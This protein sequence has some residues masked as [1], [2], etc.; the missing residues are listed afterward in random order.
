[1]PRGARTARILVAEQ[2]DDASS[3]ANELRSGGY[4]TV[5]VRSGAQMLG[6]ARDDDAQTRGPMLDPNSNVIDVYVGYLRRKLGADIIH[7]VRG[8]GYRLGA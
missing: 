4:S 5:A 2:A 8:V 6:L 3:L 1:M 7:T